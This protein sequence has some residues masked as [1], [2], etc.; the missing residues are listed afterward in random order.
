[1]YGQESIIR[2]S[3][4]VEIYTASILITPNIQEYDLRDWIPRYTNSNVQIL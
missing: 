1:M 3:K 4:Q 2:N